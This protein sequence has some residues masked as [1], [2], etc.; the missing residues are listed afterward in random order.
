LDGIG[1]LVVAL[2]LAVVRNLTPFYSTRTTLPLHIRGVEGTIRCRPGTTDFHTLLQVWD[3]G[4]Y[5]LAK[6]FVQEPVRAVVDLGSNIGMSVSY[7]A[8]LWPEAQIIAVEP[9]P[10]NAALARR[11]LKRYVEGGR[12][13]IES[14]FAGSQPGFARPVRPQP[15]GQNA[16]RMRR[17]Q[18][19]EDDRGVTVKTMPQ[20]LEHLPPGPV[21]FVKCD[22]EGSERD[23]FAGPLPWLRRVRAMVV[24]LHELE[25]QWLLDTI[26]E[27]GAVVE[28]CHVQPVIGYDLALLWARMAWPS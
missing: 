24:E 26:D 14:C 13:V 23:I 6:E 25:P 17:L 28:K 18:P 20:L 2:C 3:D 12:V 8:T 19:Q 1:S 11:N 5:R 16:V 22:I 7:F 27:A 4:E 10:E 15:R 21:D 9:D